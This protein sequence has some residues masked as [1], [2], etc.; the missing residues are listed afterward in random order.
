MDPHYNGYLLSTE[1]KSVARDQVRKE[2]P[3]YLKDGGWV[4]PTSYASLKELRMTRGIK[5]AHAASIEDLGNV[6]MRK[7]MDIS[8]LAE[9]MTQ[10][11]QKKVVVLINEG[12]VSQTYVCI[13]SF[14]ILLIS[15]YATHARRRPLKSLQVHFMIMVE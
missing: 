3:E 15:Y 13:C 1:K 14:Y 8:Q 12:T 5:P 6:A 10:K 4:S 9:I 7:D 2:H 11:S